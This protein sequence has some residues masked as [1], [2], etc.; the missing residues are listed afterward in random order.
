MTSSSSNDITNET[1]LDEK[2]QEVENDKEELEAGFV[3]EHDAASLNI[4]PP[5]RRLQSQPVDLSV[6]T[7]IGQIDE[8]PPSLV[9]RPSYQRGYV[10]DNAR[11]S[12]LIES[13]LINI[14]IPPCYLAEEESG[15]QTVIDGQQRLY[16]IWR[17]VRGHFNLRGLKTLE[18]YNGKYFKGLTERDQ[19]LIFGRTI[20]CIVISRDSHPEI[21]F[22]VF[23][24]LNTGSTKATEQEIRNA[25]YH[26]EFNDLIKDLA[27]QPRW[28]QV[29][30]KRQLD[31][32][33]RDEELIVRFFAMHDN[34]SSYKEPLRTF[35]NQYVEAKTFRKANGV[36]KRLTLSQQEKQRLTTLFEETV[37]KA[38][39]VFGN[40]A[41]RGYGQSEWEKQV[42][43]A[44]FDAVM[45]IFT[46]LP[47]TELVQR[48]EDIETALKTLLQNEEFLQ[49]IR[50]ATAQRI[51]FARRVN[52]FSKAMTNL[53]LDSGMLIPEQ[54]SE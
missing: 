29:L 6:R 31:K 25:V 27:K 35:L 7:I 12:R 44:L 18:E 17:Y 11:A 52:M 2:I 9:V 3:P 10:W 33:M 42:N 26:G 34:Y 15:D 48:R 1:E 4:A 22:E 30:G 54:I 32:R 24:R 23:G 43:R 41:F 46:R 14:P 20:R 5:D 28:L 47:S 8:I 39:Q 21:R 40:H 50:L 19:R 49:A 36:I 51:S 38:I 13:L 53:G 37:S 16:S 45:L